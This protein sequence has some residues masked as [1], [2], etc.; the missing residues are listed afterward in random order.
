MVN[1]ELFVGKPNERLRRIGT[2]IVTAALGAVDPRRAVR[3][4]VR[5]RG[6][7]LWVG[8]M[9][10]DLRAVRHLFVVG[11]GKAGAPMAAALEDILG[12]RITQGLVNVKYRYTMPLRRVELVEAGHPLP[13]AAGQRGAEAMLKLASEAGEGDL[14]ICLLSGGGS[15]LLPVPALGITLD[16]KVRTTDLLLKSGATITEINTVRK[17][18]SRIKGGQLAKAAMP[19]RM[20]VLILSDVVGD[21]LDAIASGPASPDPSTYAEAVAIVNRYA[22]ASRLPEGVLTHLRRGETGEIP[23]TPKPGDPLFDQVQA[24]IVG[25]GT[26]AA[27]AAAREARKLGFRTLLVTTTLEGE[28]REAARVIAAIARSSL[29]AQIPLKLPAC[30]L[31]S[32]E[33][34]VTVR[35]A[36]KGG[37][38][39]EFALSAA[40]VVGG[41]SNTVVLG[42][43]T[44]G[45][46]GPTDA[47]GAMVDGTTLE[48]AYALGLDP[49]AS[50]AANDAYPFFSALSDLILTGPTNTNVSDLY[51]VLVGA[52]QGSG[53]ATDDS[54]L[55]WLGTSS[56]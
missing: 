35:G 9:A 36:G 25:N 18:L 20:V 50:L 48:R 42:F 19:A 15:A 28:A 55:R 13:D 11:G 2:Q 6:E 44:D 3:R 16:E 22:L 17:H 46:D 29:L 49:L 53:V 37:R 40:L 39:Q 38:C 14:V 41:W 47:A 43:G 12:A 33:T 23:D 4:I 45:T 10:Y 26:L 52:E 54:G 8:K 31:A 51:L 7:T 21:R 34:T 56:H 32:G 5:R 27:R 30:I 1:E 24:V